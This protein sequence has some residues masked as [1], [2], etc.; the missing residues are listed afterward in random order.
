MALTA[1]VDTSVIVPALRTD[2]SATAD[3]QE[4]LR[5]VP[6]LSLPEALAA[7]R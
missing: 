3:A 1:V 7:I 6:V 5:L 4:L 2:E